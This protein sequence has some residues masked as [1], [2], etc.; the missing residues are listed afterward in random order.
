LLPSAQRLLGHPDAANAINKVVN[1]VKP[2]ARNGESAT[3]EGAR[4]SLK[5][6]EDELA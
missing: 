6:T 2:Q 3:D 4:I 1:T 5:K